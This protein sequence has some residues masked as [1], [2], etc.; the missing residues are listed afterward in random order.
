M[1]S[2]A[3]LIPRLFTLEAQHVERKFYYPHRRYGMIEAR[4]R[5]GLRI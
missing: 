2:M 4:Q 1:L 5:P 3:V